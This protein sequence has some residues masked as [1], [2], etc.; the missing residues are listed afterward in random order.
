MEFPDTPEGR[1]RAKRAK[2][3]EEE[4]RR[5]HKEWKERNLCE[6]GSGKLKHQPVFIRDEDDR[7]RMIY[8]KCD[9]KGCNRSWLAK[10]RARAKKLPFWRVP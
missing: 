10:E 3:W 5:R 8:V 6:C 9:H 7:S 1:A 2:E 4:C